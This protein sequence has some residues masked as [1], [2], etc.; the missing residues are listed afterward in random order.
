[1]SAMTLIRGIFPNIHH[2]FTSAPIQSVL[3]K[4]PSFD[5]NFSD[6]FRQSHPE[7][8]QHRVCPGVV[9]WDSRETR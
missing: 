9:Q 3:E 4:D 8:T 7:V 1:M 2:Q 5:D 6:S